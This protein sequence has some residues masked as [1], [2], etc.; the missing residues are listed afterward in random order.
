MTT[1][2]QQA[3]ARPAPVISCIMPVYNAERWVKLAI[4]SILNQTFRDFELIIIDDGS[5]DGSAAIIETFRLTDPRV[6]VIAQPNRG[7]VSA[8]NAGVAIARGAYIA[9]MDADDVSVASRFSRQLQVMQANP[10]IIILGAKA[11]TIDGED[12][13]DGRRAPSARATPRLLFGNN[14]TR[15]FP[16][17]ILQVL[18]PTIMMRTGAIRQIGAY[19]ET[20]L[21]AEDYDLYLR[22]SE[23]GLIAEIQE[24][25]L[26]YRLH[27]DNISLRRL[28]E[29][30]SNAALCD[31]ANVR[32][33]RKRLG[34]PAQKISPETLLGWATFRRH[35]R[36]RTLNTSRAGTLYAAA[37]LTLRGALT[38]HP[39]ITFRILLRCAFYLAIGAGAASP[40]R[41][42]RP[43][44]AWT[45]RKHCD[46]ERSANG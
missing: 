26:Y 44:K 25:L 15:R 5:T 1:H 27:G 10:R 18:H 40:R 34:M 38:T 19:S 36:E 11:Q 2:A 37:Q 8:L 42:W 41:A 29:Q 35:R 23:L 21:Y 39:A 13:R 46:P 24:E 30:E 20:F 12:V 45:A 32:T 14:R 43:L 6:V 22:A 3:P 4:R 16:P 33:I 31:L 17:S 28:Y 9:R 7:V